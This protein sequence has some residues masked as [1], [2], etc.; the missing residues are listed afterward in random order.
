M[1]V[2]IDDGIGRAIHSDLP[3]T[4]HLLDMAGALTM[5]VDCFR[6]PEAFPCLRFLEAM[7]RSPTSPPMSLATS[8]AWAF[9]CANFSAAW[10]G[11][12]A[13]KHE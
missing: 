10:T 9:C 11:S 1:G 6:P 12:K 4:S 3:A 13:G 8:D 7:K 5:K 2:M